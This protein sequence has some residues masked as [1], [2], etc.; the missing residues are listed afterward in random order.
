MFNFNKLLPYMD[1]SSMIFEVNLVKPTKSFEPEMV[2][3]IG[4]SLQPP[5]K[6]GTDLK[7]LNALLHMSQR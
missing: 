7:L 3:E 6:F 5:G 1:R 4:V 2:N